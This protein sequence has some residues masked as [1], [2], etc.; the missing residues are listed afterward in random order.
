[1]EEL[2]KWKVVFVT[3]DGLEAVLT[4][5]EADGY[6]VVMTVH[7]P[8]AG[9]TGTFTVIGRLPDP[10]P[11]QEIIPFVMPPRPGPGRGGMPRGHA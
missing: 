10:M 3:P 7:T 9:V 8:P 1:M 6:M 2:T 11:Q 5:L 4:Q